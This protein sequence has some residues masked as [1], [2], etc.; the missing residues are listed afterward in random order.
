MSEDYVPDEMETRTLFGLQ[1]EQ[2]RNSAPVTKELFQTVV[3]KG[4]EVGCL[5][6]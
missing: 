3:T 6:C 1:M 4:G 2:K 5:G